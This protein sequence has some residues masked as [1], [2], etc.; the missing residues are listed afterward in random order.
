MSRPFFHE[1]KVM[2]VLY[3][4]QIYSCKDKRGAVGSKAWWDVKGRG[5]KML[6]GITESRVGCLR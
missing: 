6:R 5:G 3:I 2:T 1:Y 4:E